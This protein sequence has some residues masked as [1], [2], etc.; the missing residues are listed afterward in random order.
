MNALER[1]ETIAR[2]M[3]VIIVRNE[4][5][6][7]TEYVKRYDRLVGEIRGIKLRANVMANN[8]YADIIFG[9]E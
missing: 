7:N 3:E 2:A 5:G 6:C 8:D 1:L 4:Y 9:E